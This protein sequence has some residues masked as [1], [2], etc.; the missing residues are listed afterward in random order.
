MSYIQITLMSDTCIASGEIY[1]CLVD[2][3]V[4]YDKYGLP[5]IP[6]KRLKGCLRETAHELVDWGKNINI[7]KIFGE[8]GSCIASMRLSNANLFRV[9][10]DNFSESS[11]YNYEDYVEDILQERN[12]K[13]SM[14]QNVLEQFTYMRTQ[15]AIDEKTGTAKRNSLRDIRVLKKG[16]SFQAKVSFLGTEEE[17]IEMEQQVKQCCLALKFMGLN[18]T[19]GMGEV[20]VEFVIESEQVTEIKEN[21]ECLVNSPVGRQCLN[22]TIL[23]KAPLLTRS[24]SSGQ[25]VTE[26]YIEG[27]KMLGFL[28]HHVSHCDQDFNSFMRMG[29][30]ICSNAYISKENKRY[31]PISAGFYS[32]KGH[33]SDSR[34]KNYEIE[35]YQIG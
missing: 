7:K 26:N 18:R 2:A 10:K 3:D 4:C 31:M 11:V 24:I 21:L 23:L 34:R 6:A 5:Y 35:Q 28:A 12:R 22:Y 19:R 20:K 17:I 13:Y 27:S 16:L 33:T 9:E 1:N 8:A 29:E 30:L 15:T 25:E 14:P 32:M